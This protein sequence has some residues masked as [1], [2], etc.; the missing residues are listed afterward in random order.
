MIIVKVPIENS[1]DPLGC[2]KA[3]NEIIARFPE[4]Y[5]SESNKETIKSNLRLEEIHLNNKKL[6]EAH[7]LIYENAFETIE[8]NEKTIFLGGD[9]SM[10]YSIGM[11]FLDLCKAEKN[12]PFLVVFDA[13]AD[14]KQLNEVNEIPDNRQWLR[15]LIEEGFPPDKIILVGLRA[16]TKEENEFLEKHKIR[17]YRMKDLND[18]EE[19][20]DIVM[21]LIRENQIYLSIDIDVVDSAFVPGTAHP[22]SAGMTT[23]QLVYFIQRINLLKNLRAVDISEVNPKID[24]NAQTIKLGAKILGEVIGS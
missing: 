13:H 22:E 9:H 8:I 5:I 24:V 2:S 4:R 3:G 6:E 1:S 20:C 14:C 11:A 7:E 15:K 21:E 10:S 18:F 12:K 19:I 16:N 17:I 23:R